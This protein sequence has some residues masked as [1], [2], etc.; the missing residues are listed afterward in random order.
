MK[1]TKI[2]R[3]FIMGFTLIEA[4]VGATVF[5]IIATGVYKAFTVVTELAH[6]SRART[7]AIMVAN[8]K[9]E[10]A[11][12]ISFDKVGTVG[13]IPSG[14]LLPTETLSRGGLVFKIDTTIRN[15]DDSFDGTANGTPKDTAPADYKL[16]E[17]AV[18][19]L[20]CKNWQDVVLTAR[21][22]PVGLE[23]AGS[24]G[25]LFINVY[26]SIGQILPGANV[27]LTNDHVDPHIDISDVTNNNGTLQIVGA[28]PSSQNYHI[29]VSKD[30]YSTEQTYPIG[31][32]PVINPVKPDSTV[33]AENLTQISF[34]IDK[35]ST[36]NISGS[37][38]NCAAIG[39]VPFTLSG[40]KTIG[41][42]PTVLKYSQSKTL[43]GDGALSVL[44]LEWDSYSALVSS[45][46]SYYL[47]GAIPLMPVPLLADTTQNMMLVLRP[48]VPNGLLVTV[49]DVGTGLPITDASVNLTKS[50]FDS[51]LMTGRGS[52]GQTD[53]SGGSGQADYTVTN[54]YF[55]SENV[56]PNITAGTLKLTKVLN[57]YVSNGWLESS[58]FDAGTA[59]NF[60]TLVWN[61]T[62]QP[63]QVGSNSVRVQIASSD[64]K[65]PETWN[66]LGP[67]GTA[68]TYYTNPNS[69][70]NAVHNGKRYLRYKILL[71]TANT[72][73]T[74]SV[75]DIAFTYTSACMPSGQVF[76]EG[77]DTSNVYKIVV[78][79]TGY[80]TSTTKN[81]LVASGWQ[82]KSISLSPQR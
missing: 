13:G 49:K 27:S 18:S 70:I 9:I 58:T 72:S 25:S 41:T 21:V 65:T 53:W 46:A 20:S 79:K 7:A 22:A 17:V 75:T 77:L 61:P 48:K 36:L 37:A 23:V 14:T 60:Y 69:T 3:N 82:E 33:V 16:M 71:Q 15:I 76:F 11:R 62:S 6:A 81:V 1:E 51:T 64:T 19:C 43:G 40:A 38:E 30:G 29:V 80:Q 4:V 39:G 28:P 50:G 32:S 8:E 47:V 31:V 34:N 44:G 12:G 24:N 54:K 66:Y 74:P 2:H 26:N 73:Y 42:N 68:N 57:N 52:Q 35:T 78:S 56:D 5:V 45:S 67:D 55:A 10:T 63:S 59:S